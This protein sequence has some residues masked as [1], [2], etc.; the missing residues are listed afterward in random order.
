M[1]K[2]QKENQ[3]WVAFLDSDEY[4][5][6]NSNWNFQK[7]LL[8]PFGNPTMTIANLLY[9]LGNYKSLSTPCVGLPRLT[10]G[11]KE[12]NSPTTKTSDEST[13]IARTTTASLGINR[14]DFTTLRWKWRGPL[15][16]NK[17]NKAGKALVDVSRVP[18]QSFVIEQSNVHRPITDLCTVESM[19]I[20]NQESPLI[21][22][23]YIGSY[24]QWMFRND[25]R[26]IR[27][28]AK[29]QHYQNDFNASLDDGMETWLEGF[30][31]MVGHEMAKTLLQGLGQ[32][33]AINTTTTTN[34]SAEIDEMMSLLSPDTSSFV[35]VKVSRLP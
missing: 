29:Y 12:N 21:V 2:L 5:V 10:F 35:A 22:H 27:T 4:L 34:S 23:H 33:Q 17:L 25:P 3:T 1:K 9:R 8:K 24:E 16:A 26:G 14:S 6:P 13:S 28:Q 30:V 19:W 15:V 32:V 31:K 20:K 11:A 7:Q 18:W